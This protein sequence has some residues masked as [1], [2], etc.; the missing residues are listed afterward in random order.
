[1]M[2]VIKCT[3]LSAFNSTKRRIFV[4][5]NENINSREKYAIKQNIKRVWKTA[6][7]QTFSL[8]TEF[9][10]CLYLQL[11]SIPVNINKSGLAFVWSIFL[12]IKTR[13]F[14]LMRKNF[15][16]TYF[17]DCCLGQNIK[18]RYWKASGLYKLD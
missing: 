12:T 2:K 5:Q 16:Y 1:M 9:S 18:K 13:K 11:Y 8:R 17:Y 6:I 14:H 4:S 3:F 7:T 10:C 15:V